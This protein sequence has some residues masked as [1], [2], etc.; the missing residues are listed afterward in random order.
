M[1]V[2]I[3]PTGSLEI[4][5]KYEFKTQKCIHSDFKACG[6]HCPLFEE[7]RVIELANLEK[8]IQIHLCEDSSLIIHKEN[9]EDLREKKES[10]YDYNIVIDELDLREYHD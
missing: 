3:S 10:E 4:F 8:R 9:F 7:P 6:D 1:K 2:Q 5:R